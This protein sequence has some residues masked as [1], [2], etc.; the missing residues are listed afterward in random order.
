MRAE[1]NESYIE[2]MEDVLETHEQPYDASQPVM[3][4]D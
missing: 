3:C 2:K 4:L 1:F